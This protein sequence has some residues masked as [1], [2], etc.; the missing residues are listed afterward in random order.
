[1]IPSGDLSGTPKNILKA[2]RIFCIALIAGIFIFAILSVIVNQ[3]TGPFIEKKYGE[4]NV[5]LWTL[6]IISSI[7]ILIA[8]QKYRKSIIV[9]KSPDSLT[10]KLNQYRT[11]LVIYMALCEGPAL[12][13]VII[14]LLTGN[15]ISF[16][17][18]VI[19]V[20]MMLVK[21]PTTKR[22]LKELELNWQEQQ[23]LE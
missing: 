10:D 6:A 13:S 20:G 12:F 22:V 14:F 4:T 3:F 8:I 17:F 21:L 1:M 16:G 15:F 9:L 5:F 23:Q 11:A 7:C 18:I 2:T 19:M